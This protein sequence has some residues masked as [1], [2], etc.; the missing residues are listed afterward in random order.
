M[1]LRQALEAL[2]HDVEGMFGLVYQI[3]AFA[4][5]SDVDTDGIHSSTLVA[6]K[7]Q[8]QR[9]QDH[10][11]QAVDS[12]QAELLAKREQLYEF[13]AETYDTQEFCDGWS[14]LDEVCL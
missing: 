14:R 6:L 13:V 3:Q 5:A 12:Y 2:E 8:I 9:A 4:M 1:V 11:S 10:V 7:P